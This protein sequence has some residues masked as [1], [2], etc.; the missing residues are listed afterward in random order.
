MPSLPPVPIKVESNRV[1]AL[2]NGNET[3]KIEPGSNRLISDSGQ[4]KSPLEILEV[5]ATLTNDTQTRGAAI[6]TRY[7][8]FEGLR[9]ISARELITD[10]ASSLLQGLLVT[11]SRVSANQLPNFGMTLIKCPFIPFN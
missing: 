6:A 10:N 8:S 4:I 11:A 7:S 5:A 1:I 2:R 9:A 3:D